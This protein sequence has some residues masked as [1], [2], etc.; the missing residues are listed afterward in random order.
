LQVDQ[1]LKLVL[2]IAL[3]QVCILDHFDYLLF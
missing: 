2:S 3:P 1:T